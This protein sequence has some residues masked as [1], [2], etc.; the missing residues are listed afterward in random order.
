MTNRADITGIARRANLHEA[1][2]DTTVAPA[3][4]KHP[5]I[6]NRQSPQCTPY[7]CG[8]YDTSHL[9][10]KPPTYA[11]GLMQLD[12][13][14]VQGGLFTVCG[15]SQVA[16][17]GRVRSSLRWP[18]AWTWTVGSADNK[19]PW[20]RFWSS[21][22]KREIKEVG[23]LRCKGGRRLPPRIASERSLLSKRGKYGLTV[24]IKVM[25]EL[26]FGH[27]K[28]LQDSKIFHAYTVISV[29]IHDNGSAQLPLSGKDTVA[30]VK[31]SGSSSVV[32]FEGP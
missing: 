2:T 7:D 21:C 30:V 10:A 25:A 6:A 3:H 20:K 22:G 1:P 4:R 29:Y 24:V 15:I 9:Q 31:K 23:L 12:Y 14:P 26:V 11:K 17:A 19:Q 27:G 8:I 18:A 32:D 5:L 13:T 16:A 28:P